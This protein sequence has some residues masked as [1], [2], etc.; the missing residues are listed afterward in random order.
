MVS[1]VSS[2]NRPNGFSIDSLLA[3]TAEIENRDESASPEIS[4]SQPGLKL[5]SASDCKPRLS[6]EAGPKGHECSRKGF[7][8]LCYNKNLSDSTESL[9]EAASRVTLSRSSSQ[10]TPHRPSDF[11]CHVNGHLSVASVGLLGHPM[12]SVQVNAGYP[13]LN[14]YPPSL[15]HPALLTH[16]RD[17]LASY[18]WH[19]ARYG[20]FLH[21][22]FPGRF[23]LIFVKFNKWDFL[24]KTLHTRR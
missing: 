22:R 6:D 12:H 14:T 10:Y 11:L 4:T 21:S 16:H 20:G 1:V 5:G 13:G 17:P 2:V 24:P 7:C 15:T 23:L 9:R 19:L 18:N 8:L 3:R